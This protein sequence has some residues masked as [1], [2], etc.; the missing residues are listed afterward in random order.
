MC[1]TKNN[2][3]WLTFHGVIQKNKGWGVLET[4][5]T[6]YTTP[7]FREPNTEWCHSSVYLFVRP[8]GV[9]KSKKEGLETSNSVEIFS[10]TRVRALRF[11]AEMYKK[12]KVKVAGANGYFGIGGAKS[13]QPEKIFLSNCFR[14]ASPSLWNELPNSFRQPSPD[15]CSSPHVTHRLSPSLFYFRLKTYHFYKFFPPQTPG[16]LRISFLT[17]LNGFSF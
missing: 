13:L 15:H 3:K 16:I 14:Y 5:Y 6:F 17:V 9:R 1:Y 4:L 8:S 2:Q 11:R 12:V 7:P 10:V